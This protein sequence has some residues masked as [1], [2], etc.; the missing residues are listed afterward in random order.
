MQQ[1]TASKMHR[2]TKHTHASKECPLPPF[3]L[4]MMQAL[5]NACQDV[6][7]G[8][9]QQL[10]EGIPK[11]V[12]SCLAKSHQWPSVTNQETPAWPPSKEFEGYRRSLF[13]FILGGEPEAI[14]Q[15]T[16][17]GAHCVGKRRNLSRFA[18]RTCAV[19][20]R[21]AAYCM[22]G[23]ALSAFPCRQRMTSVG[24]FATL[25]LVSW[26]SADPATATE[27]ACIRTPMT[28]GK[29]RKHFAA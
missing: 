20:C 26:V 10:C 28:E 5:T 18:E 7:Q 24:W 3:R 23:R 25:K 8:L 12:F 11:R 6:D 2:L 22:R 4:D 14:D 27:A 13:Q 15:S 19:N 17:R 1:G 16:L 21:R 29:F 9:I